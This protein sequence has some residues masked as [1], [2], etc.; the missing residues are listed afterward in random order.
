MK[1]HRAAGVGCS[2]WFGSGSPT[3]PTDPH[4]TIADRPPQPAFEALTTKPNDKLSGGGRL[5][6]PRPCSAWLGALATPL[7]QH[8]VEGGGGLPREGIRQPDLA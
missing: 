5:C 4:R 3:K 7:R 6:G 2:A 8:P 1:S